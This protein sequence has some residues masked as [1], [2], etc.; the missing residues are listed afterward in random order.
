MLIHSMHCKDL[1]SSLAILAF[2]SSSA[3]SQSTPII[4]LVPYTRTPPLGTAS[5]YGNGMIGWNLTILQSVSITDIGWYDENADGL[6]RAFEV[7]LWPANAVFLSDPN[8][9][10]L[11]GDP[12]SGIF[13]PGGASAPLDGIYRVVTL[14]TAL[15]LQPGP[16]ILAGLDSDGTSDPIRFSNSPSLDNQWVSVGDAIGPPGPIPNIPT[17]FQPIGVDFIE[18]F[19]LLGPMLFISVPEPATYVPATVGL[20]CIGAASSRKFRS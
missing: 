12:Q 4:D 3:F 14:P 16:Y 17:G 20:V 11:L 19:A 18:R 10:Q 13:I 2:V 7:G 9:A 6:S 8:S 1:V 15:T 5:S